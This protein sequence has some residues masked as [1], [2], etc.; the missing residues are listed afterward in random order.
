[1]D[2][3]GSRDTLSI[4]RESVKIICVF[5]V[6]N[7]SVECDINLLTLEQLTGLMVQ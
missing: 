5:T 6:Y 4:D 2:Q 1:M 7:R 3:A